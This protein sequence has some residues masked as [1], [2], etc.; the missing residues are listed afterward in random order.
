MKRL[1]LRQRVFV[2]LDSVEKLEYRRKIEIVRLFSSPEE[3]FSGADKITKFF[4]KKR[5]L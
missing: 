4:E 3:L 1:T 5:R 2:F